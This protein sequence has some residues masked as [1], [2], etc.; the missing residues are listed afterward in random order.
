[1]R[2]IGELDAHNQLCSGDI[3]SIK[4]LVGSLVYIERCKAVTGSE[5]SSIAMHR[6]RLNRRVWH[7]SNLN[8]AINESHIT[9][10][11]LVAMACSSL[12]NWHG[13]TNSDGKRALLMSMTNAHVG[14]FLPP[15][16]DIVAGKNYQI[17]HRAFNAPKSRRAINSKFIVKLIVDMSVCGIFVMTQGSSVDQ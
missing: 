13:L 5:F 2:L 15:I 6:R 8:Q 3:E 17:K 1:V 4:I 11:V 14:N 12:I 16:G 9:G 10:S 7:Q